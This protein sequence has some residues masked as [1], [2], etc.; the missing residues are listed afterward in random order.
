MIDSAVDMDPEIA[1]AISKLPER[2]T[3]VLGVASFAVTAVALCEKSVLAA[4]MHEER[5]MQR[6]IRDTAFRSG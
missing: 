3:C 5:G 4:R 2:M 6:H 1:A